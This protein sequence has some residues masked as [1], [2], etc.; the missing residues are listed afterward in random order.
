[1]SA[2]AIQKLIAALVGSPKAESLT[3]Q[4]PECSHSF[5]VEDWRTA[6]EAG[7]TT[8]EDDEDGDDD[9]DDEFEDSMNPKSRAD[10]ESAIAKSLLNV[11]TDR[12]SVNAQH[13]EPSVKQATEFVQKHAKQSKKT[14][15]QMLSD[16][17]AKARA[18]AG[19]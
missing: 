6:E 18:E 12:A 10:R 14:A 11:A 3:I 4:C 1:M 8:S 16:A 17:I 15:A 5:E 9:D 13:N 7:S 2:S 19:R